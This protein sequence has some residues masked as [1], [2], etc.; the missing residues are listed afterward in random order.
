MP[1]LTW[2]QVAVFCCATVFARPA[3]AQAAPGAKDV[4]SGSRRL[5]PHDYSLV[6]PSGPRRAEEAASRLHAGMLNALQESK[7][8]PAGF[9]KRGRI[10]RSPVAGKPGWFDFRCAQLHDE[11]P[12]P[13]CILLGPSSYVGLS[14]VDFPDSR[15][16]MFEVFLFDTAPVRPPHREA[17][18][19]MTRIVVGHPIFAGDLRFGPALHPADIIDA[20]QRGVVKAGARPLRL[21]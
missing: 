3:F 11:S 9:P 20:L 1:R 7:L 13:N 10:E 16:Y 12:G 18:Y 15:A 19:S 21:P 14:A 5:P 8:L 2:L 17:G 4:S 6:A